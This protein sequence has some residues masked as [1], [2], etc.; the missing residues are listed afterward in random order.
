VAGQNGL[1]KAT[2]TAKDSSGL[3][4]ADGQAV[5]VY[6]NKRH[7]YNS[8]IQVT[9]TEDTSAAPDVGMECAT[10]DTKVYNDIRAS[11]SYGGSA[12]LRN[13]ASMYE[14]GQKIYELELSITSDDE[15]RNAGTWV[16]ERYGEDRLRVSGVTLSAESSDV[17]EALVATIKIGDRIAFD[18]LP[19]NVPR[20]YMEFIVEGISVSADFK[21]QT[22][23]LGLELSP[24]E[25]WNVLQVGVSTLGDGSRIAF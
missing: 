6:H 9:L 7:R 11:R 16:A 23:S 12:R 15:M 1:V 8:P 2:E 18:D 5:M 22:W 14:Y 3:V 4:F 10:D 20:N 21:A 19:E 17:I 25:L 24:A 13:K